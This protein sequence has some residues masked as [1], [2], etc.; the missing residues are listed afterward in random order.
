[1]VKAIY[2]AFGFSLF[3][4]TFILKNSFFILFYGGGGQQWC[5][6]EPEHFLCMK[7]GT[8]SKRQE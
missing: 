6:S 7:E 2:T 5:I 3:P 8:T 1:M 4:P